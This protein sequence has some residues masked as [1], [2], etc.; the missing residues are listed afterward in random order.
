MIFAHDATPF[1][2]NI[3]QNRKVATNQQYQTLSENNLKNFL[4]KKCVETIFLKHFPKRAFC[5]HDVAV[6]DLCYCAGIHT[7]YG[8]ETTDFSELPTV[9][10]SYCAG[11]HTVYGF[12]TRHRIPR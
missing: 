9:R 2:K 10:D 12:E 4:R 3:F 11:I 8:F 5:P 7:V 6:S 1:S